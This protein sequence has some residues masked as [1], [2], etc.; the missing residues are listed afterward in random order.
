[1]NIA[2]LDKN[3]KTFSVSGVSYD[4]YTPQALGL[5]GFPWDNEN[6]TFLYR[7]PD[8]MR[9]E[10]TEPVSLLAENTAGGVVRFCTDSSA[11]LLKGR[12]RPVTLFPH[13]P[14][15]GQGGF[16]VVLCT[17]DGE[18]L[19][20]NLRGEIADIQNQ[21][22]DFELSCP[23]PEGMHEYKIYL[24]LYAGLETLDIGL[25]QGSEVKKAPTH[26]V[27][28][29]LF[30][31]SSITQGG[32]ASRP[33]N[34]HAAQLAARVGA[35]QINLGFSGNAMGEANMA[36]LIADLDLSCFVMDYDYN[37]PTIE[38]LINTHEPFFKIIRERK[39]DLPVIMIS[40]PGSSWFTVNDEEKRR[41]VIMQTYLNARIKG[42]KN[43]YF[44]DGMNFYNQVVRE[45]PSV[46]KCH[47]TD[48]GFYLMTREIL[49]LLH[50]ALGL[51]TYSPGTAD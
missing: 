47:P 45:L 42:D 1:M 23:L 25:S 5:E 20:S 44:A 3:F 50:R 8:R 39:P 38:H 15:T 12:Y 16:D 27:K 46:D 32:C 28:P 31:G 10:V 19:V 2:E 33:S 41:D 51:A 48:L 29:I 37:A 40:L 49:P 7:L 30:Y 24:P 36:E 13:M 4:M 9:S 17:P 18:H 26:K 6:E 21:K 34:C 35:E 14:F 11:V 22:F 43:V